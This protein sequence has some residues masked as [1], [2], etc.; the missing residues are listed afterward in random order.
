MSRKKTYNPD[1]VLLVAMNLFWE[2]GYFNTSI[3]DL[4]AASGIDKKSLFREFGNKDKLFES[5]LRLYVT[6]GN[7]WIDSC[8][9]KKPLGLSN[10]NDFFSS[11]EYG[12]NCKGCLVNKTIMQRNLISESHFLII[13]E[14][15]EN[16]ENNLVD[17]LSTAINNN[18]LSYKTNINQIAKFLVYS[19]QGITTMA[20]YDPDDK[21]LKMVIKAILNTLKK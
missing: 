18:E 17:N 7:Q 14:S 10:I 3:A 15:I 13:Q 16:L 21:Q 20:N 19:I 9:K 11:M 12:G 1:E 4:A 8:L 6:M 5:V 2:K